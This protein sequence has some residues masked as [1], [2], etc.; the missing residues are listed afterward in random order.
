MDLKSDANKGSIKIRLKLT[1]HKLT[2]IVNDNGVGMDDETLDTL[3]YRL[4]QNT[5]ANT[6]GQDKSK[7][8]ELH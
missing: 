1:N 2:I 5:I 6:Q 4:K 7:K 3:N 8:A